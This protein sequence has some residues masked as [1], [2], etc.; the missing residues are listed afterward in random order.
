MYKI[1]K[2]T[3]DIALHIADDWK[4]PD[5]FSFYDMTEA[6]ED[7][8]GDSYYSVFEDGILIGYFC[9]YEED[10]IVEIGLR[11]RPDLIGQGK[12]IE[13]FNLITEF[14]VNE[15]NNKRLRLSVAKFDKGA[16]KVYKKAGF[17]EMSSKKVNTNGGIH[18]FVIMEKSETIDLENHLD[19]F[20]QA[21]VD[22]LKDNLV[23]IYLHG[24]YAMGCYNFKTSDIDLIIVINHDISDDIKILCM[25]ESIKFNNKLGGKGFEMSIVKKEFCN[26]DIYPIPYELHFSSF[27]LEEYRENPIKYI[28]EMQGFD[29]DL[30]AHFKMVLHRGKKLYG[31]EIKDVFSDVPDEYYLKSVLYDIRDYNNE[32][33]TNNLVYVILNLCRTLAYVKERLILSKQEGGEW[34]MENTDIVYREIINKAL[35]AYKLGENIYLNDDKLAYEFVNYMRIEISSNTTIEFE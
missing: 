21:T 28:S 9:F 11:L 1:E 19:K 31:K 26:K 24:S 2:M 6:L 5:E 20:V 22:I 8:R 27:H 35:S 16:I 14:I 25:N 30:S 4:Y 33:V 18:E 29:E 7:L 34:A 23:G 10:E 32:F 3:Q 17:Y 12:G 13:F 15:T